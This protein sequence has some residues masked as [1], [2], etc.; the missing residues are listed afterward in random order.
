MHKLLKEICR[1]KIVDG[2]WQQKFKE[3]NQWF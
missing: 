2:C 1:N 3:Q